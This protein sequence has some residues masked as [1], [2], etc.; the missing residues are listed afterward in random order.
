MSISVIISTYNQPEWLWKTL[1]GYSVQTFNDFEVLIADDGSSEKTADVIK[2]FCSRFPKIRLQHLWHEDLGYR[3][4]IILNTALRACKSSYLVITDGDCI[5]RKDFL[6]YHNSEKRL[7]TFLSGGYCKLSMKLSRSITEQQILDGSAFSSQFLISRGM[8][9]M[10]NLLK[11]SVSNEVSSFLDLITPTKATWNNCNSSGWL[12]DILAVNGFN[13]EMQYGGA[14]RELGER[15]MNY[16][17]TPKQIR[18]RAICLHLEHKRSYKNTAE[19]RKNEGIRDAIQREK[20]F[21]CATG[22]LK[23]KKPKS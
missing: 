16:G 4:Q 20:T 3:R 18:N 1:L 5:P 10:S 9:K 13:E 17:I 14:D 15:L 11:V 21:W 23:S 22:I 2:C 7:G 12:D 19:I 6:A 8:L